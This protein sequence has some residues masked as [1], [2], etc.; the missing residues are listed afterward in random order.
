M[1][2]ESNRDK[3]F[4]YA[5]PTGL[6]TI[7]FTLGIACG[8]E[9]KDCQYDSA[10]QGKQPKDWTYRNWDWLDFLFTVL[11]GL[12]GNV[13]LVGIILMCIYL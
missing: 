11:G 5:I 1:F 13:I 4:L 8:L 10:N 6:L 2:T 9:F 12:I 7:L 3:H